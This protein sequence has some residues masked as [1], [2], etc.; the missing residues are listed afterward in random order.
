MLKKSN[1]KGFTIIEVL[2]VLAI[3]GLIMLIVFLAVPA[4]QRNSRN[5]TAR[6]E[7]STVLGGV[8]EFLANNNGKLPAVGVSATANSD[9]QKVWQNV[10]T[11]Q[12]TSISVEAEG[13]TTLPTSTNA[14]VAL[15]AKCVSPSS[16][17]NAAGRGAIVDP[18]SSR[19]FAI[20][21]ITETGNGNQLSCTAG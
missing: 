19:E 2:I 21:Y 1:Q 16:T 9:A 11:Q 4:L 20:L 7:A 14:I 12:L 8:N 6:S 17:L 3:A 15:S 18:G 5:T 10:K 13:G